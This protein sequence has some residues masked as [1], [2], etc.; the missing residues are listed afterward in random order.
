MKCG[1]LRVSSLKRW[2]ILRL[3]SAIDNLHYRLTF[4]LV[5]SGQKNE[6]PGPKEPFKSGKIPKFG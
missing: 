5:N 6:I 3:C 2:G 4:D 1:D